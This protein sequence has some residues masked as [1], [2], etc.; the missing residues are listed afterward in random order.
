MNKDNLLKRSLQFP[1]AT[2]FRTDIFLRELRVHAQIG[3][4]PRKLWPHPRRHIS[5]QQG[6]GNQPLELKIPAWLHFSSLAGIEPFPLIA[7]R[8]GQRLRRLFVTVHLALRNQLRIAAIECAKDFAAI[9][10]EE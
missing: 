7:W 5:Q 3:A 6:F 2:A 4:I 9:P 10:D 8:P 1:P